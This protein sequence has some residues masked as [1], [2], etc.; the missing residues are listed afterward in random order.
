MTQ[1]L[2]KRAGRLNLPLD[3]LQLEVG[4]RLR[5]V[6]ALRACLRA[7]QDG[8][9]AVEAGRGLEVVEAC[10]G[11]FITRVVDP[12]ACLQ[13]RCRA[14]EAIAVP[15]VARARRRAAG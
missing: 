12:A 2:P 8:V 3:H 7:V 14:E 5:G 1:K 6:E 15:P 10:A 13:K 9:A 11:R 4:N